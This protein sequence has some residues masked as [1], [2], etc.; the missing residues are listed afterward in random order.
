MLNVKENIKKGLTILLIYTLITLCLLMA[1]SRI[2]RLDQKTDNF[3]N[4]NTSVS[5][6]L[7]K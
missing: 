5:L 7:S 4:T 1:T 6:N 2:E 3:R